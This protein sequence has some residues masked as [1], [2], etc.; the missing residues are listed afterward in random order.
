MA[1][2]HR[3]PRLFTAEEYL[4]IERNAPYKSEFISGEIVTMAGASETHITVNFNL[5]LAVGPSLRGTTCRAFGNDMKVCTAPDGLFAYPDLTIVCGERQYH[6]VKHDVLL[7]PIALFEILSPSTAAFDRG[8]K[9][10]LYQELDSL[11]VY[12]LISQDTPRIEH[13]ARQENNLWFPTVAIGLD[14]ALTLSAVPVTLNLADVY[15]NVVFGTPET[16]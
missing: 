16:R 1:A 14:S 6:D 3:M 10:L 12:I 11:R 4:M 15:E 13:Y 8:E 2:A 9:F 7:N 5:G